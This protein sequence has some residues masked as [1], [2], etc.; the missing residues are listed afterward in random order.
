MKTHLLCLVC[1][2]LAVFSF[3]GCDDKDDIRF[4]IDDVQGDII[5][6][7]KAVSHISISN[8]SGESVHLI[9]GTMPYTA[10]VDIPS[11]LSVTME[12]DYLNI[13]ATGE[14]GIA[15][16]TVT[17]KNGKTAELTV[18]IQKEIL[19]ITV[20]DIQT[21]I[22]GDI[23]EA[24]SKAITEDIKQNA[25]IRP[26]NVITLER[27][28]ITEMAYEGILKI[29]SD[30]S[31][32]AKVLYEGTF[33]QGYAQDVQAAYF[34]FQYDGVTELYFLGRP[35][36]HYPHIPETRDTGPVQIYLGRNLTSHYRSLYPGVEEVTMALFGFSH[37]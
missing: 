16:V 6:G 4:M 22:S 27:T 2:L 21:K 9:G 5:T 10:S 20:T 7:E 13:K 37:P 30:A 3:T 24:T 14:E 11:L 18:V 17:D 26:D 23:D 8:L 35:N 28:G 32:S 33:L 31:E 25:R 15:K 1:C 29:Y 36:S 12:N 19:R 34:E